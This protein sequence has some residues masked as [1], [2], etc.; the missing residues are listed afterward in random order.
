MKNASVQAEPGQEGAS[1]A[2]AVV[3]SPLYLH[4]DSGNHQ[5]A[6]VELE[7][8]KVL[9]IGSVL[10]AD[11]YLTD[12]EIA[13][14]HATLERVGDSVRLQARQAE[15]S[16]FGVVLPK[17]RRARLQCDGEFRIGTVKMVVAGSQRD[18]DQ[19]LRAQRTLLRQRA[20]LRYML[21]ELRRLDTTTRLALIAATTLMTGVP[22]LLS[23]QHSEPTIESVQ[24]LAPHIRKMFPNVQV[25]L[26]EQQAA[27]VYS[28]YVDQHQDLERLRLHAWNVT[29]DI[30]LIHVFA[31]SEVLAASRT[32][33]ERNY[34]SVDL[35]VTGP[36]TLVA[37]VP[38]NTPARSM[39]AWNF[40]AIAATA[41]RNIPG[42]R[43]IQ[44]VAVN[45]ELK[46]GQTVP[47]AQ[48][49]L[50]LV[51]SPSGSYLRG[52]NGEQLFAG[53][54]VREGTL[55]KIEPCRILLHPTGTNRVYRLVNTE[56]NNAYCR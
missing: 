53:A 27:V 30:P 28:G 16:L 23:G 22:V 6:R 9:S 31:M 47:L 26:D 36:G 25:A 46:E 10:D 43:H 19:A 45:T 14:L 35:R 13:P 56:V 50:N 54:T 17:Q 21:F 8:G 42:L 55:L 1:T 29:A 2:S 40:D 7:E 12:A 48:L 18:P 33:L 37:Y 20:P 52:K 11:I 15:I 5:G 32:Y 34:R 3:I 51:S 24:E 39:E 41:Q 49:G 38:A 44:V 4:I